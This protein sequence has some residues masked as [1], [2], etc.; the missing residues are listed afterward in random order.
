ML[1]PTFLDIVSCMQSVLRVILVII[2]RHNGCWS[3][4]DLFVSN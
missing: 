4:T 2:S 1:V 3:K